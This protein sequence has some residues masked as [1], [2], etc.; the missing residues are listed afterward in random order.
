MSEFIFYTSSPNAHECL[1]AYRQSSMCSVLFSL[2]TEAT[3]W[4]KETITMNHGLLWSDVWQSPP[5]FHCEDLEWSKKLSFDQQ[6][7]EI[8]LRLTGEPKE[9]TFY[10]KRKDDPEILSIPR[11]APF[12]T[13]TDD[14]LRGALQSRGYSSRLANKRMLLSFIPLF[15]R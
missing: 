4:K 14:C 2:S 5:C 10:S 15:Y 8:I 1:S 11:V 12:V 6:Q 3:P 9:G 13:V 7:D